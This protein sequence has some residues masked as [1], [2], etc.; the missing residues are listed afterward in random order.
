MPARSES[1]PTPTKPRTTVDRKSDREL[2]VTRTINGPAR[3]VFEAWSKPEVFL[4]WWLPKS[5][6]ISVVSAEADVR[7]GGRYRYVFRVGTSEPMAFFGRY[8]EVT[9]PSKLVWTNEETDTGAVTTVTLEDRGATTLLVMHDL[10]PSKEALEAAL[11][12]GEK[13]GLDETFDQLDA[14]LV[15][16]G[17]GARSP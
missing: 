4:Q 9:P 13:N 12:S 8:L 7:T 15:R 5:V 3:L 1:Q 11:A 17:D 14:L 6:G 10:Y 2:V 16:S